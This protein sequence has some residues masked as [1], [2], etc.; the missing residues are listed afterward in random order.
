[1]TTSESAALQAE[2]RGKRRR[3]RPEAF[4]GNRQDAL[5]QAAAQL[6]YKHGYDG[7]S[8]RDIASAVGIT[9]G[10]IF[11]HFHSKEEILAAVLMQGMTIGS[12]IVRQ[13]LEGVTGPRERLDAL[14]R[15]HLLALHGENTH[16][17]HIWLQ[18]MR[19]LPEAMRAPLKELSKDYQALWLD[20]LDEVKAAELIKGDPHL[21]RKVAIGALN[22]TVQWVKEPTEAQ[23]IE[24]AKAFTATLLN[25]PGTRSPSLLDSRGQISGSIGE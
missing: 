21:F 18:D 20:V 11:Y 19:R 23:I 22:W 4:K 3:G 2:E 7:A 13:S 24:L 14:V 9:S 16:F 12:A 1:M 15:G 5:V 8:V 6:F 10:S 25:E 17:H